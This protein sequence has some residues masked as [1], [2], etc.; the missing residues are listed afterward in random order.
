MS[1]HILHTD[2]NWRCLYRQL[3]PKALAT[4]LAWMGLALTW[5]LLCML[6]ALGQEGN[7]RVGNGQGTG[8][9]I[10]PPVFTTCA[11][12]LTVPTP[13]QIPVVDFTQLSATDNSGAAVAI[14]LHHEAYEGLDV[15]PGFCPTK[16]IR[17]YRATDA[18]GNYAECVQIIAVQ[19]VAGCGPCESGVPFVF[20]DLSASPTATMTTDNIQRNE[21][22]CGAAK[23]MGCVSFNIMLH[24]DA[25]GLRITVDG[26]TPQPHEWKIDCDDITFSGSIICLPPGRFRTFTFCKPGA[27]KNVFSITSIP[28]TVVSD[29]FTTRAECNNT[30][31]VIGAVP[32]TIS[33]QDITGNGA[34]LK[35]L[36]NP[37]GSATTTFRAD[38]D[39]PTIVQYR[40]CGS[41]AN[42]LSCGNS[43]TDCDTIT[44]RVIPEITAQITSP[45]NFCVSQ[46]NTV[47]I[48]AWPHIGAY[49]YTWRNSGGVV[50][51][52]GTEP[53]FH[54]PAPGNYTVTVKETQLGLAC[55][56]ATFPFVVTLDYEVPTLIYNGGQ[57]ICPGETA[58]WLLPVSGGNTIS[59]TLMPG[60]IP[61][62]GQAPVIS[63]PLTPASSTTYYVSGLVIDGCAVPLSPTDARFTVT[64]PVGQHGLWTGAFDNNWF[65]CRNWADGILPTIHTD[66][67][68]PAAAENDVNIDG[69]KGGP[70]L[71]RNILIQ[72]P[73]AFTT[74]GIL[75]LYGNWSNELSQQ[76]DAGNGTVVL[77]GGAAQLIFTTAQQEVFANVTVAKLAQTQ[78]ILQ[79]P[80]LTHG[81]G[82][83][84][85]ES[86]ILM[87][88]AQN[89]L[90][91]T[92][93]AVQAVHRPS[94]KPNDAFVCGPMVRYMEAQAEYFF[95]VGKL[96]APY[97]DF[98][99][100]AV[101]TYSA[102]FQIFS[103]E[104]HASMPPN[105]TNWGG[106]L[107]G[108]LNKEYWMM[109]R[110]EGDEPARVKLFYITPHASNHWTFNQPKHPQ[111]LIYVTKYFF[112]NMWYFTGMGT[113]D[114]Y[115]FYEVP[116]QEAV[117]YVHD[118]TMGEPIYSR[119]LRQF[120]PFTFGYPDAKILPVS[121]VHFG[122][123][124][125][126]DRVQLQWEVALPE[127][128]DYFVPEYSLEGAHF[129]A[130]GKVAATLQ[131]RYSA[132][133]AAP[134][135]A[136]CYYRI[137][138]VKKEGTVLYSPVEVLSGTPENPLLRV[139]QNPVQGSTLQ[140]QLSL[141]TGQPVRIRL[142][143]VWGRVLQEQSLQLSSGLHTLQW[144]LPATLSRGTYYLSMYLPQ[145]GTQV[146]QRFIY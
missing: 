111:V 114:P 3:L 38:A 101:L 119:P 43:G 93:T 17:T 11:P 37:S 8:P 70:A 146:Q 58:T 24:P 22:C 51:A 102:G 92:N 135:G 26:A 57:N 44:I 45:P 143:D 28:G 47:S 16:V 117:P 10:T 78:A 145:R 52:A 25:I 62:S 141:P 115:D 108:I 23:N 99:P 121:F 35:Y 49:T 106:M 82:I 14:T 75:H 81:D 109:S 116:L 87:T 71:C 129:H 5:C 19:S 100:A 94:G 110:L 140:Y 126:Q 104:Y 90:T 144:A 112:D 36:S 27:N 54:P 83:F 89:L 138:L 123:R 13:A 67:V 41:L 132:A 30:I 124:A 55:D 127:Q 4:H 107:S 42:N 15:K 85:I 1:P 60:N 21:L 2:I 113:G 84:S 12:S 142:R 34:F 64:L 91:V 18:C 86:G 134:Q 20:M 128:V 66:V 103:A 122:A 98:R 139:V 72:K 131:T 95:P 6:P 130:L 39:A 48:E 61:F 9:D 125:H 80:I 96:N 136:Y 69:A 88:S 105:P 65:D 97:I 73:F 32:S 76:F 74:Q 120:S 118:N 50:V 77:S 40:V 68:L 137:K 53:A 79:K 133:Y 7:C 31:S 63:I 33:F 29:D 46:L 56:E 59:G